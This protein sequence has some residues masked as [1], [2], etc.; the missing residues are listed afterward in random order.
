MKRVEEVKVR[1]RELK[2]IEAQKIDPNKVVRVN[3][4]N[5]PLLQ[6]DTG[7]S[8][9]KFKSVILGIANGDHH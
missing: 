3:I 1:M 7:L 8:A 6:G 4:G 5:H 2:M 9:E